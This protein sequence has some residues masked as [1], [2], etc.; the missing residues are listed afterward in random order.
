MRTVL[1]LKRNGVAVGLAIVAGLLLIVSGTRGPAG[2]LEVVLQRLSEFTNNQTILQ[3][4]SAAALILIV[5]SSVG[6]F[7]VIVGGCMIFVNHIRTGK[8]AIGLGAGVGIPW[9]IF[10][11]VTLIVTQELQPIIAQHSVVGWVGIGM[12]FAARIL[13]K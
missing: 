10:I 9:L 8:L 3:I 1:S 5:L 6:G 2:L 13:A 11:I 4:A 12:S 7:L